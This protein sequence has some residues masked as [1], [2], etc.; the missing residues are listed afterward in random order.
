MVNMLQEW[1][2]IENLHM[3][4]SN[5]L[6][7]EPSPGLIFNQFWTGI[8][9]FIFSFFISFIY[10]WVIGK[11][12]LYSVW[13]NNSILIAYVSKWNS[14]RFSQKCVNKWKKQ[15]TSLGACLATL[16]LTEIFFGGVVIV[17]VIVVLMG[18]NKVDSQ[19]FD[20]DWDWEFDKT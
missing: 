9:S 18:G 19:F 8:F 7:S 20:L 17:I 10:S 5:H 6:H 3:L 13:A 1:H 2:P 12:N 14:F 11:L 15:E 4:S 16:P